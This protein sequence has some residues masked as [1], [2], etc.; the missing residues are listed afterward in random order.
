[1]HQHCGG[2]LVAFF[3]RV[4]ERVG[5]ELIQSHYGPTDEISDDA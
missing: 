4:N 2:K 5:Y 1:M 3:F